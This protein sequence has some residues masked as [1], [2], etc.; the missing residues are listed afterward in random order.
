MILEVAP[1]NICSGES[2]AFELAF[3]NSRDRPNAVHLMIVG[4]QQYVL[5]IGSFPFLGKYCFVRRLTTRGLD[6]PFGLVWIAFPISSTTSAHHCSNCAGG[7]GAVDRE[8]SAH[9][10]DRLLEA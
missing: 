3:V 8:F 4:I 5:F 7:N 6:L 1:L 10:V 2:P 9:R